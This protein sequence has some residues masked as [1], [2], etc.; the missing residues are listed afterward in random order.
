MLVL[1]IGDMDPLAEMP[2]ELRRLLS[3]RAKIDAVL[4]CGSGARS[5]EHRQLLQSLTA[6]AGN[7]HFLAAGESH[8]LAA[9]GLRVCLA[10]ETAVVPSG[11]ALSLL[12][13]ARMADCDVLVCPQG[14]Q[15]AVFALDGRLFV[16][17]GPAHAG[18]CLL[19]VRGSGATLY[20]YGQ[21]P[22]ADV[23]I[24]RLDF[25]KP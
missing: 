9:E 3:P 10:A 25:A 12:A 14:Q 5:P 1:L 23:K 15:R 22:G 13:L 16:S 2:A 17:P 19:D 4:C 11:D 21:Q 8:V 24:E 6:S 20:C 18:F 7:C